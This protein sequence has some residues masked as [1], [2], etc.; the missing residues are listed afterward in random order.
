[1]AL[2]MQY[3]G[4]RR[5]YLLGAPHFNYDA[6]ILDLGATMRRNFSG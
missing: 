4:I 3:N 6:S 5:G 1:M 2:Q